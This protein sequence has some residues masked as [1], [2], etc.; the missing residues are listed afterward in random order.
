MSETAQKAKVQLTTLQRQRKVPGIVDFVK[1][2]SRFT[3]LIPK[4]GIKLTLVLGG[5]R[6]PRAPGRTAQEKG[7]P[8]GQEALELANRRC[9]QRDCEIDIFDID[10]VG[11]FIGSLY[12]NHENFAK[13]LA[14]E[15]L[16]S[17]HHYSA[18]KY[19]NLQELDAAEKKAKEGKK[20]L[21]HDYDP[22]QDEEAQE[23]TPADSTNESAA[24]I[25]KK[26][27]D[28]RD[29][30]VTNMDG[31]GKLKIQEVG[32][33][34]AALEVLMREFKSF[35]INPSNAKSMK[36]APKAG[37]FV[38]AKFDL[39]G[40]WYRARIR[41]NDRANKQAEV[42]YIDYGNTAKIPWSELR[43][44][45]QPQ[46]STQKLK[47]Q[48]VDASLSFVQMPTA[49][50]YL[51]DAIDFIAGLT[52][53]RKLVASFDFVDS[54]ENLS[55][56]TLYDTKSG[57]GLP[58]VTDSIN[59]DVVANGQG[60]VPRKLKPWERSKPFE[61]VLKSLREAESKAKQDRLGMWEYGDITE[62]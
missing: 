46:F 5:V 28:Y 54:K 22:S 41:S 27:T 45:D 57:G 38:A 58:A 60:L 62:D 3:I 20:G 15:G 59:R 35:H 52:A 44:L 61:G 8:F 26:P 2:G 39:D 9:N 13:V 40:E 21:W 50:H 32:K 43:P 23:A 37:D 11:G 6:A 47:A 42:V 17:V 48:A 51:A 18:E 49:E 10:K 14:E 30:V 24:T 16:A 1:A 31:N 56:I 7:E 53:D 36:D 25:D 19:G 12:V 4:E 29:V 33:G 34:T 55:Y